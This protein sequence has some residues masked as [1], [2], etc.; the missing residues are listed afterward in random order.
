MKRPWLY[1]ISPCT[2][3]A[4]LCLVPIIFS[5]TMENPDG[6]QYVMLLMFVPSIL[7]LL[8]IDYVI[9][10]ATNGRVLYIWIIEPIFIALTVMAV[11][12]VNPIRWILALG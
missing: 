11:G 1:Y 8:V 9:K 4:I 3:L 5:L 7:V 10:S 12:L 6:L 2:I